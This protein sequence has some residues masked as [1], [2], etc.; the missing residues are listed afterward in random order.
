M[1]QVVSP[2]QDGDLDVSAAAKPIL[3]G[4]EPLLRQLSAFGIFVPN[5]LVVAGCLLVVRLTAAATACM[6]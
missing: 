5:K 6:R 4:K 1:D 2:N 3:F